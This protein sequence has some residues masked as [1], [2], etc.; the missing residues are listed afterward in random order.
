M[1]SHHRFKNNRKGVGT[2]FGMV[3]FL[4]IAVIIFASFAVLLNENTNLESTMS[5]ARELDFAKANEHVLILNPIQPSGGGDLTANL[6]NTGS[7][8]VN[9]IRIW[10]KPVIGDPTPKPLSIT[11][12]P[13]DTIPAVNLG[14]FGFDVNLNIGDDGITLISDRGSKFS[15]GQAVGNNGVDGSPGPA[16]ATGAP[17]STGPPGPSGAPGPSGSP[18]SVIDS[19]WWI[20]A[21]TTDVNSLIRP[22]GL[23]PVKPGDSQTFIYSSAP[24]YTIS[25]V[26]VDGA[27]VS[28]TGSYTFNT[29]AANHTIS[30]SSTRSI[31]TITVLSG[32]GGSITPGGPFISVNLGAS[33]SF[34]ISSTVSG[35]RLVDVKIDGASQGP[36]ASYT[37]SNVVSDHVI[38]ATFEGPPLFGIFKITASTNDIYSSITPSGSVLVNPGDSQTFTYSAANGYTIDKLLVDGVSTPITGSYT[39]SNVQVDHTISVS[40]T[41]SIFTITV[42]PGSGGSISPSGP[43]VS[44]NKGASQVFTI[45]PYSGF[46]IVGISVD[47]APVANGTSYTFTNVQANHMITATFIDQLIEGGLAQGI[48]SIAMEFPS[49]SHYDF[50]SSPANGT[51]APT[52]TYAFSVSGTDYTYLHLRIKNLDPWKR[53]ITITSGSSMWAV[54]PFSATVKGDQWTA[55]KLISNKLY[56]FSGSTYTQIL[57]LGQWVDMY[58]GPTQ[59]SRSAGGIVPLN[60]LLYGTATY[61]NGT[62]VDYGQNLPFIALKVN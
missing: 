8:A 37:F 3:F 39:F 25:S 29:V 54:T 6:Q 42:L 40:S 55:C 2:I 36:I 60:I 62:V 5:K 30:V 7:I 18:G 9:I 27:P 28:I 41:Q 32:Y 43:Y 22:V 44:V 26:L 14:N 10:A 1:F 48:G 24:G 17:G 38:S 58:F 57:P 21:S 33:Q 13:G 47:G 23:V 49:F 16:G 51:T 4:L 35:Y 31:F 11:I 45:T 12:A 46:D 52:A 20:T 50:S 56:Y 15:Y 53:T 59:A 34:T 61:P 19:S